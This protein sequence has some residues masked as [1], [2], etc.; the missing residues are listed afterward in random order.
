MKAFKRENV[1]SDG[2]KTFDIIVR[3]DFDWL[4]RINRMFDKVYEIEEFIPETTELTIYA[5]DFFQ[6]EVI[7]EDIK[8]QA[9]IMINRW[10]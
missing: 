6:S 4:S 3:G 1:L 5:E 2:S 9:Y 10:E 8:K 7:M